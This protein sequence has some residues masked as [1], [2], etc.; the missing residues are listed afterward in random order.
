[1]T[2][3]LADEFRAAQEEGDV[4]SDFPARTATLFVQSY[5]IGHCYRT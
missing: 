5:T 2:D 3:Q 4:R 1:M